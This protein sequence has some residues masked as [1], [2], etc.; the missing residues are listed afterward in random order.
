VDTGGSW[1]ASFPGTKMREYPQSV[2]ITQTPASTASEEGSGYNMRPY[3]A[4]AIN[5]GHFFK[6]QLNVT[7]ISTQMASN[8][9]N[10]LAESLEN[11]I[12]LGTTASAYETVVVPGHPAGR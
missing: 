11:P 7:R 4:T 2:V 5:A 8:T 9:V 6:E 12:E 1:M 10:A 3:Y